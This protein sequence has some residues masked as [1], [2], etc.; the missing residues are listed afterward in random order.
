MTDPDTALVLLVRGKDR[1]MVRIERSLKETGW[2][3]APRP[4]DV[5]R[6]TKDQGPEFM[7]KRVSAT[8]VE[9]GKLVVFL[10]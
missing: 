6:I 4:G 8:K 7:E 9:N 10:Q 1:K 5:V 3:R 2:P